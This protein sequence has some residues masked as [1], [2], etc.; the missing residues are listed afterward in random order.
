MKVRQWIGFGL[1]VTGFLLPWLVT[2]PGLSFP[3][4]VTLAIFLLA[5]AFWL[6]EPVPIYTTS[7]LVIFLEVLLL[8][9]EGPLFKLSQPPTFA[10]RAAVGTGE[11]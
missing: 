2:W 3:G 9:A 11:F 7:L 8:S 6:L 5:V 4:Q 10:P 1:G